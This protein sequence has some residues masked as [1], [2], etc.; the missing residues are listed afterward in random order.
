VHGSKDRAKDASPKARD[1]HSCV[2]RVHTLRAHARSRSPPRRPPDIRC[3]R[4]ARPR[5]RNPRERTDRPRS[6]FRRRPAKSDAFPKAR[7]PSTAA[8]R[9]SAEG[10]DPSDPAPA[11][12]LTPPARI[13]KVRTCCWWALQGHGAVTR[14]SVS[15]GVRTPFRPDGGPCL[16]LTTQARH[17]ARSTRPSTR[18]DCPARTDADRSAPTAST[19][20]RGSRRGL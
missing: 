16:E 13:R 12:P 3:R 4:R 19:T 2:R 7:M 14:E 11:L 6:S 9:E 5:G 1:D 8:T 20:E 17:R 15:W 10:D 18:T